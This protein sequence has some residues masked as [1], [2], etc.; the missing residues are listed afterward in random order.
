MLTWLLIYVLP[1]SVFFGGAAW[2]W[3]YR[4][5]RPRVHLLLTL[6]I[7][8]LA[9]LCSMLFGW[10]LFLDVMQAGPLGSAA[11]AG[12][13]WSAIPAIVA[14]ILLRKQLP[15]SAAGNPAA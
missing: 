4:L 11:N 1:G 10:Y 12:V 3:R 2:F 6:A 14:F 8:F 5:Q 9:W 7:A 15:S 13:I